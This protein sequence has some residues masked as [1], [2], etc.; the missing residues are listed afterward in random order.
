MNS[1]VK[2]FEI[3][4]LLRE[5]S[6]QASRS[7]GKGGQNVN[8]VSSKVELSFDILNSQVLTEEQ[9][10]ILLIKLA[11]KINAEGILKLVSQEDRAQLINKKK[12]VEKFVALINK[13]FTKRKKRIPTKLPESIKESRL[14]EKRK[15]GE[16]KVLRQKNLPS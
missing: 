15:V 8:K 11:S 10:N 5:L 2:A 1:L 6:F 9:K 4:Q 16:K 3:D 12:V 7:G 13:S 14:I